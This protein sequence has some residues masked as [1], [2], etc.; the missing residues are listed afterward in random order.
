VELVPIN[1]HDNRFTVTR[2]LNLGAVAARGK[3]RVYCHQDILLCDA[4]IRRV[5]HEISCISNPDVGMV[6]FEGLKDGGIPYSCKSLGVGRT[7]E[8]QTLDEL[9]ILTNRKD[10][11]FDELFLFHYY[12]ADICL[13]AEAKG[14]TNYLIGVP[15]RHL[16]GGQENVTADIEGFKREA[17]HF[18]DKWPHKQ[19]WTTT[20]K[21]LDGGI[22]YMMLPDVLND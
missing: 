5:K 17:G 13:Q 2:A 15:T 4:W 10:I 22:Y 8:V 6:G 1:N 3:W 14:L 16:S 11:A 20:T 9:C 19:V 21:F 18:R 7:Q 12:G